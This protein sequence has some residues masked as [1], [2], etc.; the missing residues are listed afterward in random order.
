[1]GDNYIV[2]VRNKNGELDF[3]TESMDDHGFN[4]A[5]LIDTIYRLKEKVRTLERKANPSTSRGTGCHG[6][7]WVEM[8]NFSPTADIEPIPYRC[9]TCGKTKRWK[10]KIGWMY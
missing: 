5:N 2:E 10:E 6:H 8:A 9:S 3:K 4:V 1:M 7:D